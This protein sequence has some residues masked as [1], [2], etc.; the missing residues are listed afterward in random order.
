MTAT[1]APIESWEPA[2][3]LARIYPDEWH[4]PGTGDPGPKC[5][6]DV[7]VRC[8]A[9]GHVWKAPK[10]CGER[11][12]PKC[13]KRWCWSTA[14]DEARRSWTIMR[15]R[16][17]G[18]RPRIMH[19]V[20]SWDPATTVITPT[21]VPTWRA[22]AWR[23]L[24]RCGAV[25]AV[26]ILHPWREKED[27]QTAAPPGDDPIRAWEHRLERVRARGL[28]R[29]ERYTEHG[30]HFHAV[31]LVAGDFDLRARR[32]DTVLKVLPNREGRFTGLAGP[33]EVRRVL[34]YQLSHCGI[35]DGRHA[36]TLYG[37]FSRRSWSRADQR[38]VDGGFRRHPN[39]RCPA[40]GS[41]LTGRVRYWGTD[42][43]GAWDPCPPGCRHLLLNRGG[44]DTPPAP[45]AAATGR[46]APGG[47]VAAQ[48]ASTSWPP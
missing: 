22:R 47:R 25:G 33:R 28:P 11:Q 48:D 13:W 41:T 31:V 17:R 24:K 29:E 42:A 37:A 40:C 1:S 15:A 7:L 21:D 18:Q 6:G 12:C 34:N 8:S 39:R 30:P 26:L 44:Q 36:L 23:L 35:A 38:E 27:L 45:G 14:D 16:Y 2:Q 43:P 3:P 10:D 9:C 4:L 20:V 46:T 32:R 5:G 19:M